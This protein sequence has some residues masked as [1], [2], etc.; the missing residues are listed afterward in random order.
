MFV[1]GAQAANP[2]KETYFEH[3]RLKLVQMEE[4]KRMSAAHEMASSARALGLSGILKPFCWPKVFGRR[5][6]KITLWCL[7]R[8]M[9][10]VSL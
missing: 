6:I 10:W 7:S 8:W 3:G 2:V 4:L 5:P 9:T 1:M